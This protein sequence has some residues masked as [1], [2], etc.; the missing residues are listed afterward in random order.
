MHCAPPHHAE[1]FLIH[2]LQLQDVQIVTE[3]FHTDTLN[4]A[5]HL[6]FPKSRYRDI[7]S[8]CRDISQM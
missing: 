6:E 3:N 2:I 5:K 1:I 4:P 7:Y 8:G